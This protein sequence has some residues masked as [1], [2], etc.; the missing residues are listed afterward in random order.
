MI[1]VFIWSPLC[2][3]LQSTFLTE[4]L[5]SLHTMN[6]HWMILV[7][8]VKTVF[9]VTAV[10]FACENA[11][12]NLGGCSRGSSGLRGF[13]PHDASDQYTYSNLP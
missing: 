13:P 12:P 1:D 8:V 10:G 6:K 3:L 11:E 9:R 2:I 4:S 5:G 7:S